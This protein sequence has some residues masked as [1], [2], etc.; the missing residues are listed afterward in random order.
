MNHV[1]IPPEAEPPIGQGSPGST[2]PDG[3]TQPGVRVWI[4]LAVAMG[5]LGAAVVAGPR[6]FAS[7]AEQAALPP[8][9][10][11]AV[12]PPLQRNVE[13]RLQ[14]LGRLSAL[15]NVELRAQV[16]GTLT[17]IHFKDGDIVH[18]G[19]LL[20]VIDPVPYEI[21]LSQAMAQLESAK[22]HLELATIELQRAEALKRTNAGSAQNVDQR[23]M[24][25]RTAQAAV[26][27]AKA[28]V[29]D[30]QF[31]LD[32]CRITAPFTGR[33]GTH[34]VS[35]GNLVAGSRAS[36]SPTTLLA[37]LVSLDPIYLNFDMSEAD[38]MAFMRERQKQGGPLADKVEVSLSDETDFAREGTLDFIDNALDRSSGAIHARAT[39]PN[40]DHFLTPGGFARVRVALAPPS[41]ALLVPDAAILPD[42]SG[43]I[44]LTVGPNDVVTPK[45]VEVDDLRGG[46]RVV[47]SGLTTSDQVIIDGIPIARPDSKVSP[48][49]GSI[50]FAS[51]RS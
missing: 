40:G 34:L 15:E 5:V 12:S 46:L 48:R 23:A 27:G 6:L 7:F 32:H 8:P 37:T 18:K 2:T 13:A 49:S 36:S 44:V 31:D 41:P 47:R 26:D 50:H 38:Y 42:Q 4:G 35:V 22:A 16:G 33:I 21:K 25:Q 20:F 17:E 30:A 11:V 29:R 14:F 45:R 39:I 10:P 3:S 9:P 1:V 19:D 51:D 24:E 28:Q 43:H